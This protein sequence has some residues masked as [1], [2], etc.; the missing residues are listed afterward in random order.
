MADSRTGAG[1]I[2]KSLENLVVSEIRNAQKLYKDE[3]MPKEK[4]SQL[5]EIPI[6]KIGTI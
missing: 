2:Q 6:A 3:V 4:R 1:N 5:K